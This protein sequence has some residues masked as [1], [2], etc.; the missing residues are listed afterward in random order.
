LNSDVAAIIARHDPGR[1][2]RTLRYRARTELPY[3]VSA[4]PADAPLL[5]DT[6]VYVDHLKGQ[7]PTDLV[8]LIASRQILH[9]APAVAELAVT[10]GALDPSDPRTRATL[11]PIL[12]TLAH[13]PRQR[14]VAPREDIWLEGALMAGILARIQGIPKK[15][16]RKFLNDTVMFL[17]TADVGAVLV[18]RNARDFDLLL[19][20]KP[21][22]AVLLYE[23]P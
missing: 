11:V 20:M 1:W 7:L 9:G 12:D 8:V 5:L 22:G 19:Q 4:I 15:D 14:I 2:T 17:M 21:G 13:I 6:T 3:E 23:R 16:R 10:V 18:S